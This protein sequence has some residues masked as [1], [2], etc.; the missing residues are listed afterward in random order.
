MEEIQREIKKIDLPVVQKLEEASKCGFYAE[1]LVDPEILE[2]LV[3]LKV[4]G[5][6]AVDEEGIPAEE[7]KVLIPWCPVTVLTTI[8]QGVMYVHPL[9]M[10]VIQ[11]HNGNAPKPKD[12]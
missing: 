9:I 3:R 6:P 8:L 4:E 1:S 12:E 5:K 11:D 2:P 7:D 10:K